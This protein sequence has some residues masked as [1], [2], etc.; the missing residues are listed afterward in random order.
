[1]IDA[2]EHLIKV[3]LRNQIPEWLRPFC[4]EDPDW[5]A[6][7]PPATLCDDLESLFLRWETNQVQIKRQ[8]L[9]DGSVI[10]SS[11]CDK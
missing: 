11:I 10:L 3:W 4:G 9:N 6:L 1:M 7:L 8:T 5:I 2:P